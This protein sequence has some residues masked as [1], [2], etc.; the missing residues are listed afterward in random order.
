MSPNDNASN[1]TDASDGQ[2]FEEP[3]Q[4]KTF[5]IVFFSLIT[6]A[7]LVGNT[8]MC[9]A[10]CQFS[11]RKPF[12]FHL[13]TN[14]AVAEII[15][16]LCIPFTFLYKYLTEWPFGEFACKFTV[17]LRVLS[18]F[19]VTSTLAAIAVYR[20]VILF[21][22]PF[23]RIVTKFKMILMICLLWVGAIAVALP[24]VM[25][26]KTVV[27]S[28][29]T[30]CNLELPGDDV[31]DWPY[32]NAT[33]YIT[34]R[35]VLNFAVPYVIMLVSYSA[36]AVKLKRHINRTKKESFELSESTKNAF[37]STEQEKREEQELAVGEQDMEAT[38]EN[39]QRSSRGITHMENDLLRMIYVVI[40]SF[41]V[42]YL[43]YQVH[44]LF[45]HL[46]G[47]TTFPEAKKY[48][49]LI[50]Q[51]FLLLT[52]LPSALHPLC[53]GTMSKF[54]A[55]SF[56]ILVLCRCRGGNGNGNVDKQ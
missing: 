28:G 32:E 15:S 46:E 52:Y 56:T 27:D 49:S 26:N 18:I 33:K 41:V 12:S 51:Y 23:K 9:K 42:C 20:C 31:F 38:R 13:V 34:A 21:L 36:V 35:F 43:P 17:S 16:T 22:P 11:A 2:S 29:G 19:E 25:Y 5:R 47:Y 10:A 4:S 7:S 8:V 50:G 40:L 30:Q 37:H 54:Y 1:T 6:L 53:Y 24:H 55:R 45:I 3:Q 39:R 14:L 48:R 44:F